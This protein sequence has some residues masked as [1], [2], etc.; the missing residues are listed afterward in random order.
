MLRALKVEEWIMRATP[1][2]DVRSP[3][4]FALG[5]IPG[6]TNLPLFTDEERARVGTLY[7]QVGRE[8]AL[9][10]GLRFVGPRMAGL[11]DESLRIAPDKC[12][13]VHC[14][15]GGERSVSVGWLLGKAGFTEV[16]TL[17]GGYKAFRSHARASIGQERSIK[18]LGGFTGSGKTEV[19]QQ[20]T[21]LGEQVVDL[22]ALASHKGSSFGALGQQ[23]QPTT[24]QF[25]NLLWEELRAKDPARPVWVEDESLM[26][27]RVSI[28]Q[29]FFAQ[30]RG[31]KMYF[32][33]VPLEQR[34][35]R[36]VRDY[37]GFPKEALADAVRRIAKRIG[38]QHCKRAL[39][40]LDAGDLRP[41][42]QITLRYYD[43]AYLHGASRRYRDKVIHIDA[44]DH[45]P[46][47]LARQLTATA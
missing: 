30:M 2:I 23:P 15:R 33:E 4:E 8:K 32:V 42:A 37:G 27:G 29:A 18:V 25:E 17:L 9:L 28:P 36:L 34:V 5:H 14:W 10:E 16:L 41:V 7:K 11:V 26:I 20:L 1:V 43:K 47:Y 12:I 31:A 46:E 45:T 39:E 21:A 24:E 44:A 13:R 6:A 35:D 40:A 19:L 38:P 3:G 22:E